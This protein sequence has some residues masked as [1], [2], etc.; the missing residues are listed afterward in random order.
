MKRLA[1]LAAVI[2]MAACTH[3]GPTE[4]ALGEEF[5]LRAGESATV[6]PDSVSVTFTKVTADSRCPT[7]VVCVWAG[8]AGVLLQLS[9][10]GD[11]EALELHTAA[12][13]G[14]SRGSFH[15]YAVQLVDVSP[16]ARA[17]QPIPADD[18]SVTLRVTH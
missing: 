13:V 2:G 4:A 15:G 18:Y 14:P 3:A 5:T 10:L 16:A 1:L 8:D 17:G 7:N 6:G 9:G 12:Q 11:S